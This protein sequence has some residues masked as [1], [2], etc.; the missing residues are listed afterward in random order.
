MRPDGAPRGRGRIYRLALVAA[1]VVV[2]VLGALVVWRARQRADLWITNDLEIGV[3]VEIAG[4]RVEARARDVV[5]VEGL[6]PR[7]AHATTR[8]EDGRI[9]DEVDVPLQRSAVVV[10]DVLGA[11]PLYEELVE[12]QANGGKSQGGTRLFVGE[13]I[14]VRDDVD[15]AFGAPKGPG[16]GDRRRMRLGRLEG[17]DVT[18]G[19][20]I[21]DDP[22]AAAAFLATLARAEPEASTIVERALDLAATPEEELALAEE[23]LGLHRDV[24]LERRRQSVAIR[25]GKGADVEREYEARYEADPGP[26]SAYLYAAILPR[27]RAR[28]VLSLA[29][30]EIPEAE[31]DLRIQRLLGAL[32][33][34]DRRFAEASARLDRVAGAARIHRAVLAEHTASLVA[35]RGLRAALDMLE[36][37][38]PEERASPGYWVVY[39]Q[40]V[41]R[42]RA[43][44]DDVVG[45]L[46]PSAQV[47]KGTSSEDW[48][49]LGA[50]WGIAPPADLVLDVA[51]KESLDVALAARAD[52][53]RAIDL[54]QK[55]SPRARTKI[56]SFA[57]LLV[58]MEAGRTG[59]RAIAKAA[60]DAA[61]SSLGQD[62][63]LR[64]YLVDGRDDPALDERDLVVRAIVELGRARR[65]ADPARR[66]ALEKS[67]A[68]DDPLVGFVADALRHWPPP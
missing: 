3:V 35:S 2:V 57:A 40:V 7:T 16:K 12:A 27:A 19:F 52:P 5:H 17:V 21:R 29:V 38:A 8:R 32:D 9:I 46:D 33:Y 61:E 36:R 25:L 30:R 13:R 65:E 59:Q 26:E 67:A 6:E 42:A 50:D 1:L 22:R 39:G 28:E 66:A 34:Q 54:F 41:A 10:L 11:S 20:L 24:D 63:P 43:A 45:R 68:L 53:L 56:V 4:R 15:D 37:L 23:L 62:P 51:A 60:M 49:L 64:A 44:H 18:I 55:A 14:V 48:A 31:S 47:P 58:A